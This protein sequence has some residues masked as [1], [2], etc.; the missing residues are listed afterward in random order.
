MLSTKL[1]SASSPVQSL[2]YVG[3]YVQGFAGT[4]GETVISLTS[5]TG[6]IASAPA[7]NDL[8]LVTYG[9]SSITNLDLN[10][11]TAGYTEVYDLYSN[12]TFDANLATFYK[13][14]GG[15]PDTSFSCSSTGSID[16]AGAVYVSVWRNVNTTFP[17]KSIASVTAINTTLPDP[18]SI[19]TTGTSNAVVVSGVGALNTISTNYSSAD[20]SDFK[21]T[22]QA[23][24]NSVVIGGGYKFPVSG[25]F[26]PAAFTGAT[27]STSGS[28]AANTLEIRQIS[29][30]IPY[31]VSVSNTRASATSAIVTAPEG[32]QD[33]DILI[34]IGHLDSQSSTITLPSGFT[35]VYS[36]LTDEPM[37]NVGFKIASGEVGNYTFT[38]GNPSDSQST[39]LVYRNSSYSVIGTITR[40][41]G[42][43]QSTAASLTNPNIG[44]NII[45]AT[46]EANT[47]VS[48]VQSGMVQ[49]LTSLSTNNIRLAIYD[50]LAPVPFALSRTVTWNASGKT[51]GIQLNITG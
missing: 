13:F 19:S 49:R 45:I 12:D 22:R 25:T 38:Y 10:I 35:S 30:Q 31:F 42:S 15:T 14:M 29:Q 34:A 47:T 21:T 36:E 6:G 4:T 5:L 41:I 37:I 20:L 28:C 17:L 50:Q 27:T 39:I 16:N 48:S 2:V 44:I 9:V 26:D 23:D 46:T 1:K 3:G 51:S 43:T 24:T 32:I 33:G 8:V 11:P 40:T 7:A 18:P